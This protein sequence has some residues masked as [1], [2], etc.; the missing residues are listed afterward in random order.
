MHSAT[1]P[2]TTLDSK[3]QYH[4]NDSCLHTILQGC[5]KLAV[6]LQGCDNLA[7]M[8]LQPRN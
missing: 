2:L 5:H 1:E 4:L 8:L 7:E 6:T 3:F